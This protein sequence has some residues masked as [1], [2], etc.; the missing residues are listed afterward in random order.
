MARTV[1]CG[2]YMC[3]RHRNVSAMSREGRRSSY[4][5]VVPKALSS[6]GTLNCS[7]HLTTRHSHVILIMCLIRTKPGAQVVSRSK[8]LLVNS[9]ARSTSPIEPSIL[10]GSYTIS[11]SACSTCQIL[12]SWRPVSTMAK[13]TFGTSARN[14]WTVGTVAILRAIVWT[15]KKKRHRRR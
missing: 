2:R 15:L 1:S 3:H 11:F 8:K 9:N 7:F 10:H 14:K 6:P 4:S 5:Q 13:S 12:T